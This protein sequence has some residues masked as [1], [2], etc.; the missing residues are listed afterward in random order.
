MKILL[1]ALTLTGCCTIGQQPHEGFYTDEC[2][3]RKFAASGRH[4]ATSSNYQ[5][6]PSWIQQYDSHGR[7]H[8]H[9]PGEPYSYAP[10]TNNTVIPLSRLPRR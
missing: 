1:A 3:V 2:G 8:M 4:T 9:P 5:N 6:G 10:I 7:L